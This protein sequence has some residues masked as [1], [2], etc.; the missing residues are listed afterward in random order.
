[1][2]KHYE[3]DFIARAH[4]DGVIT[5]LT[6]TIGDYRLKY[7]LISKP[8]YRFDVLN[9]FLNKTVS[10]VKMQSVAY[11]NGLRNGQSLLGYTITNKGIIEIKIKTGKNTKL[12]NYK[13]DSV[14][15]IIPQYEARK[16]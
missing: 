3:D 9:S 5:N 13:P 16:I 8:D 2:T 4:E 7:L 12:I 1:M 10:G 11:L 6:S 15:I 14:Y